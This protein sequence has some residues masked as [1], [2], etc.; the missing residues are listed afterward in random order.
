MDKIQFKKH[1]AIIFIPLTKNIMGLV[2]QNIFL[3][4]FTMFAP[5]HYIYC[6]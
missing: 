2:Y 3:A 1:F 5:T 4:Q 6:R